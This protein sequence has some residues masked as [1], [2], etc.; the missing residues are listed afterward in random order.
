MQII[1]TMSSV[2]TRQIVSIA[3]VLVLPASAQLEPRQ[4]ATIPDYVTKYGAAAPVDLP[5]LKSF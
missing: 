3:L 1:E 4:T 5:C 2:R